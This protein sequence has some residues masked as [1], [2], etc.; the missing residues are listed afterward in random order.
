[1]GTAQPSNVRNTRNQE[2]N[3]DKN[4][5]EKSLMSSVL[6]IDFRKDIK[7][8]LASNIY[9]KR[10]YG[11]FSLK[12]PGEKYYSHSSFITAEKVFNI[13]KQSTKAYSIKGYDGNPMSQIGIPVYI[14][15]DKFTL[16]RYMIID[17]ITSINT[18]YIEVYFIGLNHKKWAVKMDKILVSYSA[19]QDMKEREADRHNAYINIYD[20]P[21]SG[22]RHSI[23]A[24]HINK[25]FFEGKD[26]LVNNIKLLK[27]RWKISSEFNLFPKYSILLYGNPGTGK[28][29][30]AYAVARAMRKSVYVLKDKKSM[31]AFLGSDFYNII[32][33]MDEIDLVLESLMNNNTT[34]DFGSS[35]VDKAGALQ[36][37]LNW[38]DRIG[39]NNILIATT[40][41]KENL[42]DALYRPGRF[43]IVMEVKP[44]SKEIADEM[45]R[46]HGVEPS[47]ILTDDFPLLDGGYQQALI[48]QKLVEYKY[49]KLLKSKEE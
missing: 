25:I 27:E 21:Y 15:L 10:I 9:T 18:S 35:V 34:T 8:I 5:F 3:K 13:I 47:E 17:A 33:L 7:T 4:Y 43:N 20:D 48:E 12:L 40:N 49:K 41:H 31:Q 36:F 30:F 44:A 45:C 24:P 38:F 42:P 19:I 16:M 23:Q 28:T 39:D 14:M 46:A 32:I 26:I 6:D 22:N 29:S 1:M 11:N 37:L 2:D